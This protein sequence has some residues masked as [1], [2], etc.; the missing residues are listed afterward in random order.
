MSTVS[1]EIKGKEDVSTAAKKAATGLRDVG[2]S[3]SSLASSFAPV[4]IAGAAVIGAIREIAQTVDECVVAFAENE[5]ASLAFNAA[6][7]QSGSITTAA[8]SALTQF[9][10]EIAAMTGETG[11]SVQSME[12]LLIT[13]GR[14]EAEVRKLIE[15]AV[16][17]SAATGKDLRS[18]VEQLNKTFGGTA[19]ELG[20]IIPEMKSLTKEQLLA[21]EAVDLIAGKYDGLGEALANSVDVGLK[22]YK[23]AVSDLKAELG[24]LIS[25]GL[26]PLRAWLT[27]IIRQWGEAAGA[28]RNYTSAMIKAKGGASLD[29]FTE[30]ELVALNKA[31]LEF[32]EQRKGVLLQLKEG[33]V[34]FKTVTKQIEDAVA[35]QQRIATELRNMASTR[36]YAGY[37]PAEAPAIPSAS[38]SSSSSSRGSGDDG[39]DVL[40]DRL[41]LKLGLYT[42]ASDRVR[43]QSGGSLVD[44]D[45]PLS[46]GGD[47][48][49]FGGGL[50]GLDDVFGPLIGLLGDFAGSMSMLQSL[51]DPIGTILS[52]VMDILGPLIETLLTPLVGIFRILGQT[53]GR[54]IA[55]L[56]EMLGPIIKGIAEVFVWLYNKVL[57]P[58]GN[59][60]ITLFNVVA[61]MVLGIWNGIV[62]AINAAL[63]WAGVNLSYASYRALDQGHLSEI[64]V[65]DLS[66]AGSASSS[67][68][69]GANASYSQARD[70]TVNVSVSTSALVGDDGIRQFSLMIWRE[71]KS[72]GVLGAA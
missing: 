31:R 2:S 20:E 13:S 67:S 72:A 49:L 47:S 54:I 33:S 28:A 30:Q 27:D 35:D 44:D 3:A 19:G 25:Q 18:S 57:R 63:G 65:G 51:L 45:L 36:H 14:T 61:N 37:L 55:P 58:I 34:D 10:N 8:A 7:S 62:A 71:I 32:I 26:S 5:R 53:L 29:S 12:T 41:A 23:N 69:T 38:G 50:A 42:G 66:A 16:D 39:V 9:A 15:A 21:G 11:A 43:G 60:I 1:V 70:I 68:T 48:M 52:G 17:M 59:G 56:F 46:R 4:A 22:N 24:G 40:A 64:S 6:I